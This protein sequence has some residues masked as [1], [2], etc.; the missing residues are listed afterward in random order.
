[1]GRRFC[2]YPEI[3][4]T[5]TRRPRWYIRPSIPVLNAHGKLRPKLGD[6]IYLGFCDETPISQA[7]RARAQICS[8]I[9]TRKSEMVIPETSMVGDKFVQKSGRQSI[10]DCSSI[11]NEIHKRNIGASSKGT[12]AEYIVTADLMSKGYEVFL[13]ADKCASCDI[14][15]YDGTFHRIEVKYSNGNKNI[16]IRRQHG[17][18]DVLAV[19]NSSGEIG[20]R[21]ASGINSATIKIEN[22]VNQTQPRAHGECPQDVGNK[23]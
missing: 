9:N 15:A 3:H 12:A 6:R 22:F 21:A 13:S 14:V 16:P 23:G 17:K 1:M 18:F 4:K 11:I 5:S 7:K 20:Y 19:V 2:T 10:I 8:A